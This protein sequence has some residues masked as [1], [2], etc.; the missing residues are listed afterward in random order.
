[1]AAPRGPGG[2]E[3]VIQ[4]QTPRLGLIECCADMGE[5]GR[6]CVVVDCGALGRRQV[7]D[8]GI[9]R[10]NLATAEASLVQRVDLAAQ[11]AV[12]H[13]AAR[14]PPA[15]PRP[16]L[17]GRGF[18]GAFETVLLRSRWLQAGPT[19]CAGARQE[20]THAQPWSN[21]HIRAPLFRMGD[22]DRPSSVRSAADAARLARPART[23]GCTWPA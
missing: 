18:E 21:S 9:E 10:L 14:P 3:G 19:Q 5:K 16:S 20:Q 15:D 6:R 17:L 23:G 11:L 8:A 1:M 12:L 22:D 7:R 2:T 13:S 4:P